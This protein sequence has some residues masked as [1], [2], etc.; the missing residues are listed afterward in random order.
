MTAVGAVELHS[1]NPEISE[2]MRME[3]WYEM[4]G[5]YCYWDPSKSHH[6]HTSLHCILF[7]IQVERQFLAFLREFQEMMISESDAFSAGLSSHGASWMSLQAWH[8][9]LRDSSK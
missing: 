2:D 3:N 4:E 7:E 5:N 6:T 1:G 9:L 8:G